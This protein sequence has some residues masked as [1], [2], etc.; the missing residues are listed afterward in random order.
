MNVP[1]ARGYIMALMVFIQNI[2]VFNCRS[3]HASAFKVPLKNNRLIVFGVIDFG[4]AVFSSSEDTMKKAQGAFIK[5]ELFDKYGY[6]DVYYHDVGIVYSDN[7]YIIV[8]LTKHGKGDYK[9]I[10]SDISKKIYELNKI[11][12]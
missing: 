3:E 4:K 9:N 10:V 1:T 6:Y 12:N 8:V 2:H 7:P 5:R 11:D